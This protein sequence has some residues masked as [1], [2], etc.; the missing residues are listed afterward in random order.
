[1][2]AAHGQRLPHHCCQQKTQTCSGGVISLIS[3][4]SLQGLNV[5]ESSMPSNSALLLPP[6]L[7]S[8]SAGPH[9]PSPRRASYTMEKRGHRQRRVTHTMARNTQLHQR[10]EPMAQRTRLS[11]HLTKSRPNHPKLEHSCHSRLVHCMIPLHPDGG[12]NMEEKKK[13]TI[14]STLI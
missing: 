2:D 8:S 11:H 12:D 7:T 9:L 5:R 13:N 3:P 14:R 1:M 4:P 10:V 6:M